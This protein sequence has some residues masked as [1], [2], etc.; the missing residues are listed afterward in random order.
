MKRKVIVGLVVGLVCVVAALGEELKHVADRGHTAPLRAKL[1]FV[2]GEPRTAL[3][4]TYNT[5]YKEVHVDWQAHDGQGAALSIFL[6]TVKSLAI[7]GDN[8]AVVTFKNGDERECTFD[9]PAIWLQGVADSVETLTFNKL[10]KIEFLREP[11]LDHDNHAMF[12]H[13]RYSPFTGEKL[14]EIT[15]HD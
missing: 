6:D 11:R 2:E 14:P 9:N 10:K 15:E 3:I 13:W 5:V 4:A 1:S 8:K 12:D 7:T